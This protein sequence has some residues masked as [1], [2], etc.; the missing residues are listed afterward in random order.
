MSEQNIDLVRKAL[1]AY[2]RRD[3][4]ALMALAHPDIE[5]DWSASRGLLAGVYQGMDATLGFYSEYFNV[6][7]K[8]TFE[9]ERF[10][11]VGESVVVP[12]VARQRGREGIE[13][14]ARSTLVFTLRDHLI[15][16]IRLYQETEQALRAVG[17]Q[18]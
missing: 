11:D 5:L 15:T 1:E 14:S 3:V 12:N 9:A 8:I 18:G 10:I 16:H 4:G 17:L 2:S 13:V 7:E 6:F